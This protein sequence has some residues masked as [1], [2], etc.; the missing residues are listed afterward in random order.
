MEYWFINKKLHIIIFSNCPIK[1]VNL[2]NNNNII[3]YSS[4]NQVVLYAYLMFLL[5]FYKFTGCLRVHGT[6]IT[7]VSFYS[8]MDLYR[9][10]MKIFSSVYIIL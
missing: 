1:I 3:I 5:W 4:F 10:Y 7:V 9:F 2:K 6:A 8:R